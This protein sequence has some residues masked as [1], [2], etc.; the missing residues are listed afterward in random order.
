MAKKESKEVK[1][2][3]TL[4]EWRSIKMPVKYFEGIFNPIT[5]EQAIDFYSDKSWLFNS[6]KVLNKWAVGEVL[7]EEEFDEGVS[8]ASNHSPKQ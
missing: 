4:E 8:K 2:T 1:E 7:S 6:A 3:K 5:G